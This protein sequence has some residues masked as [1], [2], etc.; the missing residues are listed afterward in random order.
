MQD[1]KN[2]FKSLQ[3]IEKEP[4]INKAFII[5]FFLYSFIYFFLYNLYFCIPNLCES[6]TICWC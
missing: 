2:V 4:Q 3:R 5:I 6:N 1:D